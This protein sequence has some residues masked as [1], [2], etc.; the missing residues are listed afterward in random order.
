[1]AIDALGNVYIA[2]GNSVIRRLSKPTSVAFTSTVIGTASSPQTLTILNIGNQALNFAGFVISPNFGQQVAA[3]ANCSSSTA[4]TAGG[5]CAIALGFVPT[6]SGNLS[7]AFMLTDNSL[8]AAATTQSLSLSGTGLTGVVP[9]LSFSSASLTFAAQAV[10]ATSSAQSI[11]LA[12]P[13]TAVLNISSIQLGGA[14]ASDFALSGGTTCQGTLAPKATCSIALVFS[15]SAAG[16]RTA[17]V[18]LVDNLVNSPQTVMITGNGQITTL[19]DGTA[20]HFYSGA[21]Q[22]VHEFSIVKGAWQDRDLTAAGGA[23][24]IA[25]GASVSSFFDTIQN[26]LRLNYAAADQHVHQLYTSGNNIWSDFDLTAA[27]NGPRVLPAIALSGVVDTTQNLLRIN[28]AG[29]DHHVHQFYIANGAWHDFD[30]TAVTG[31]QNIAVSG[32]IASFVD[33]VQKLLRIN[34]I[35]LDQHIH[36]FSIAGGAWHDLD[37]T[38]AASA[39]LVAS[40]SS[41]ANFADTVGNV[42]RI[43]YTAVDQHIHE[44]YMAGGAWHDFDLTAATAGPKVAANTPIDNG[45]DP[46]EGRLRINY[47]GL[48]QHIHEFYIANGAWHDF[49]LTLG[50]GGIAAAPGMPITSVID[51]SANMLRIN[52]SGSDSHVHEFYIANCAWHDFDLSA[53]T[54]GPLLPSQK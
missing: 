24:N 53:A 35:G 44:F 13:G 54:G 20:A 45:I 10:G 47:T 50:S 22:H 32:S 1:M 11:I 4:L 16:A 34:Y 21:D 18:I 17:S 39:P 52:Y 28:Y 29:V 8:N 14:N 43:N 19:V 25:T 15:P 23:P 31:A 36:Q 30:L 12:N 37:L 9:Q 27:V 49:D 7:G 40:G 48:D 26:V 3:G 51:S 46:F 2:D 38:A 5:S 33:T 41:L 42:P 6:V